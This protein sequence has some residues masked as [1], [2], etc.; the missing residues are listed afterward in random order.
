MNELIREIEEDIRQERLQKLW[1]SFG[2]LMVWLSLGVVLVTIGVVV[3]QNHRLNRAMENTTDFIRGIDRM[4]IENYKAA[5]P[6]FEDLSIDPASPYYPLAML[7]LAQAQLGL[8]DAEAARKTYESLAANDRVFGELAK[9]TLPPKGDDV[10]KPQPGSPFF[11]TLSE[12]RGW[13]LL[14][15]GQ[16][17]TAIAQFLSLYQDVKTPQSMR[18]RLTE[19]LQH[20]APAR[21]AKVDEHL[22]EEAKKKGGLPTEVTLP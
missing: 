3:L 19:V 15:L 11:H 16:K 8:S 12:M 1:N 7:R 17:D 20:L 22:R 5:I 10:P 6:I 13:Q 9:L 18:L 14:K 2:R 21:L 4:Q